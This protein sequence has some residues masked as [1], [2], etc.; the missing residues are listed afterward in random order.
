MTT[1]KVSVLATGE[2]RLNGEPVTLTALGR[3]MA[4]AVKPETVV[5][6]YRENPAGEPP[7]VAVEVMK[8]ITAN[9]LSV[10]L[11]TSPDFSDSVA[12]VVLDRVFAALREK[13]AQNQIVIL[14]PNG[15]VLRFPASPRESVPATMLA[16]VERLLPSEVKRNVAV[17]GNTAWTMAAQPTLQSANEA[18]P[19]FGLLV[20][21]STIGHAVWV[22]DAGPAHLLTAACRD[23]DVLIVDSE[24]LSALAEGWQE[25]AAKEMRHRQVLV[26]DRA[27]Y[28]LRKA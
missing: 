11:S 16:S 6:Y 5:W 24:R 15:Q 7:P 4:E 26:H 22:F 20:G 19:F 3:A 14:R 1:L 28:Q 21:L 13:A 17:L 2:L 18:I 9:K 27:T 10:R 12:P 25:S 23:A 8:L